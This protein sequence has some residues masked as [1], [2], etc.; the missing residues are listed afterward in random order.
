MYIHEA[1][2][3]EKSKGDITLPAQFHQNGK[4]VFKCLPRSTTIGIEE[5]TYCSCVHG[6]LLF[7]NTFISVSFRKCE[8]HF[9]LNNKKIISS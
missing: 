4:N 6:F 3:N 9:Y 7:Q 2:E 8:T 5:L 1:Q